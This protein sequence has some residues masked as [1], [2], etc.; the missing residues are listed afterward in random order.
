MAAAGHP[1][2]F[3][4]EQLSD[5]ERSAVLEAA[6]DARLLD[7]AAL[8]AEPRLVDSIEICWHSLPAEMW[9]E[10]RSLK[11]MQCAQAGV[12]WLAAT[13]RAIEH[14]AAITNVHIHAAAVSEH[15]W[16][17]CL[18][19]TR[20]IGA[21][22]LQQ[23]EQSWDRQ[24]LVH[25]MATLQGKTACIVGLGAIGT[26]CAHLARAFGMR[27]IGIRR[28]P[29]APAVAPGAV[30]EVGGPADL[31]RALGRSRVLMVVVPGT[32]ATRGMIGRREM[33]A[34]RGA[35]ILNAGRGSCIDTDAL[36]EALRDG[37][38]RGAGLDV[39]DPEPLPSGHPLWTMPN[40]I[41]TPHY[42]GSHP[43]YDREAFAAFLENLGLYLRGEPLRGVVDKAQGY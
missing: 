16:G 25:G 3:L 6:P 34:L 42:A 19:L 18:A 36:V 41:I 29:E 23:R 21:A 40:V 38:V 15:L 35:Y 8:A 13:P 20:H 37:G 24:S 12:E 22:V 30:D 10:A 17:L 1:V 9:A 4:G 43:G 11:W 39:T 31:V 26:R 33:A 7:L 32:P 28:R 14:P 5:G 2:I 27:V